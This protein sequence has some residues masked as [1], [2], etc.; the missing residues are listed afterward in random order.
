MQAQS[1]NSTNRSGTQAAKGYEVG[2]IAN[3]SAAVATI[4]KL[5]LEAN[6]P[7][8]Q[9]P[10]EPA[11]QDRFTIRWADC[12][13]DA[14]P[15]LEFL[16]GTD[17]SGLITKGSVNLLVGE[18]GSKKTWAALDLAVCVAMGKDWLDLATR[19]TS[20]LIVDEE[21]G[22]RRLKRRLF[23]TL[24]GHLVKREDAAPI[25]YTSLNLL[26]M[27]SADDVS[28]LHVAILQTNAGLVIVDA[29]ADI[30]P[31]AD[32]NSVKDVQPVFMQLRRIAEMTQTAIIVIHHSNKANGGYRGSTAIKGAVDLML[33]VDSPAESKHVTFK[34]E[35]ARDIEP[36]TFSAVA[37]FAPDASQFYLTS[38]E[39][40]QTK[41]HMGKGERFVLGYLL[42]NPNAEIDRIAD[43][44]DICAPATVKSAVYSLADKKYV[45]R[46]DDRTMGRGKKATYDL[47]DSGRDL[48]GRVS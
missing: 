43:S 30:M 27:R 12:V 1:N 31:G 2:D 22:E 42:N 9:D 45:T 40:R 36:R 24:N 34:A 44:A 4:E 16:V 37:T 28:A 38:C 25:A 8:K 5:R 39:V 18:G 10:Q 15:P 26:D 48:V 23:E 29:L 11:Q 35:K 3:G 13:Y 17:R 32:E 14:A 6:E 46:T 47:T 20:V 33:M 21:S 7:N 19:Q 41:E